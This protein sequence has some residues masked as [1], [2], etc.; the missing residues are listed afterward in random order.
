MQ[1]LHR[2]LVSIPDSLENSEWF[3]DASSGEEAA[4]L[5]VSA[6]LAE[7]I[8]AD[9][10]ELE[11]A[12]E[13]AVRHLPMPGGVPRVIDWADVPEQKVSLEGIAA[14]INRPTLDGPDL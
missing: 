7:A 3:I 10:E 8:S 9:I 12:G 5:Y 2:F 4:D 6:V 13:L 11:D 1:T 14:W